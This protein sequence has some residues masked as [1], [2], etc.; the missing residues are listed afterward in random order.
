MHKA[1]PPAPFLMRPLKPDMPPYGC[2]MVRGGGG[3]AVSLAQVCTR[4]ITA[5]D[6]Q[7]SNHV[8]LLLPPPRRGRHNRAAPSG[9][10]EGLAQAGECDRTSING[11]RLH[12]I[13]LRALRPE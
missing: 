8:K 2:F 10:S 3:G 4:P 5:R 1:E 9:L 7:Q 12:Y 11:G 13:L 6:L